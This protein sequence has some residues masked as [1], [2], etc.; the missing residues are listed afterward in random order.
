MHTTQPA[1]NLTSPRHPDW[2]FDRLSDGSYIGF[3]K[4]HRLMVMSVS[5]DG[6]DAEIMTRRRCNLTGTFGF[7]TARNQYP[8]TVAQVKAEVI[9]RITYWQNKK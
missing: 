7:E 5:A 4:G 3:Y 2:T 1:R 9:R 8:G 6:K